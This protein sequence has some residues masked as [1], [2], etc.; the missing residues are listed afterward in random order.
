MRPTF[1]M[2]VDKSPHR[3]RFVGEGCVGASHG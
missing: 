1:D 3:H 2:L